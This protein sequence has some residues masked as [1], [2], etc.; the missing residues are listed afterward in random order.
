[1][2]HLRDGSSTISRSISS[3]FDIKQFCAILLENLCWF[4]VQNPFFGLSWLPA[5][6]V[7]D[8]YNSKSV[9]LE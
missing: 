4:D 1:M 9:D 6:T 3:F 2:V 8:S 5:D 7:Y